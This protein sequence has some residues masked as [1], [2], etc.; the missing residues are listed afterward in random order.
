MGLVPSLQ[1][2]K[3]VALL[4]DAAVVETGTGN[5][6]RHYRR[7]SDPLPSVERALIWELA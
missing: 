1:G 6:L 7:P 4:A 2:R 3:V 5:R